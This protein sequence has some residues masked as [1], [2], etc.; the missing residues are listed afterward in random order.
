[1]SDLATTAAGRKRLMDRLQRWNSAL[2]TE[3]AV[4]HTLNNEGPQTTLALLETF[5][6]DR[7]LT[8]VALGAVARHHQW[9]SNASQ[10]PSSAIDPA[11]LVA[12]A[13]SWWKKHPEQRA[14]YLYVLTQIASKNEGAIPW[15]TLAQFL[16]GRIDSATLREYIAL[17]PANIAYVSQLRSAFEPGFAR[18]PLLKEG[19]DV[20]LE[21][22]Q[23]GKVTGPVPPSELTDRMILSV[24]DG[25]SIRDVEQ[26]RAATRELCETHDNVRGVTL[27]LRT[28]A[29]TPTSQLCPTAKRAKSASEPVLFGD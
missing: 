24:C 8:R 21:A 25:G 9:A 28:I 1:Y 17:Q 15:A 20:Y 5:S 6:A 3:T 29:D 18:A 22:F 14:V 13:P 2:L 19:L 26:L 12:A 11:P 10:R 4:V 7:D 16:G 23:A 27:Y